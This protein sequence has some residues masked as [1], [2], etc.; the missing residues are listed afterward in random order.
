MKTIVGKEY[1][2]TKCPIGALCGKKIFGHFVRWCVLRETRFA[3]TNYDFDRK[4]LL[5]K[6]FRKPILPLCTM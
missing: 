4:F 5:G 2:R 3:P 6:A 1:F